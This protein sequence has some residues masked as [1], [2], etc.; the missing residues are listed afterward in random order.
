[1]PLINLDAVLNPLPELKDHILDYIPRATTSEFGIVALGS[2]INV[3]SF[4]RIYLD[5][6]EYSDRLTA[7]ETTA[8]STLETTVNTL[9]DKADELA[10]S[11]TQKLG[12]PNGIATL[13]SAGSIPSSQLP[14]YVDDVLEFL[15]VAA[16]PAIGETGKIYVETTGNTTYRWSGTTYVKLTSGEVSS[17]AGKKGIVTLTKDDVGLSNVDNT[18]DLNKPLSTATQTA[19]TALENKAKRGIINLYDTS[20]IYG[21]NE[22][23]VLTNGDIVKSTIDGNTNDP[24]VDMT[25]W[26]NVRNDGIV[27]SIAELLSVSNPKNGHVVYVKSYNAG[28]GKGGGTFVYNS[29]KAT[30][31]DGVVNFNG[32]VRASFMFVTSSMAGCVI[33]GVTDD[34]QAFQRGV[35]YTAQNNFAFYVDDGVHY[36]NTATFK[37][38]GSDHDYQ[39]YCPIIELKYSNIS[40]VGK[41][42]KSILKYGDGITYTGWDKIGYVGA[43]LFSANPTLQIDNF[44]LIGFTI[45]G[46]GYNNK[47]RGLNGG[48]TSAGSQ[49]VYITKGDNTRIVGNKFKDLSGYQALFIAYDTENTLVEGNEFVDT[50]WLD[51]TNWK[52]NYTDQSTI[53]LGGTYLCRNNKLTQSY[54]GMFA[55]TAFELHGIG[56]AVGNYVEKYASAFLSAAVVHNPRTILLANSA[57]D[58]TMFLGTDTQRE[59]NN[60]VYAS[61]N[62]FRQRTLKLDENTIYGQYRNMFYFFG[63]YNPTSCQVVIT[64]NTFDTDRLYVDSTDSYLKQY[65][66]VIAAAH[67]T[68]FTFS[69][70]VVSNHKG[71]FLRLLRQSVGSI[72]TISN[73]TFD[74]CGVDDSVDLGNSIIYFDNDGAQDFGVRP[75]EMNFANNTFKSCKYGQYF[76]GAKDVLGDILCPYS[77][78]VDNDVHDKW[79]TTIRVKSGFQVN[80]DFYNEYNYKVNSTYNATKDINGYDVGYNTVNQRGEIKFIENG[81]SKSFK[82]TNNSLLWTKHNEGLITL[83]AAYDPAS[84]LPNTQ[85]EYIFNDVFG[86]TLGM[87]ATPTFDK[88]LSGVQMWAQVTANQQV[89]V[90]FRNGTASAVDIPSGTLKVDVI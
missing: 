33:D 64:G 8:A 83:S 50:G 44:E 16:F 9:E 7:I 90:Y 47:I 24:N 5:T 70:N 57:I 67:V 87:S 53:Y 41:S 51:G 30:I 43:Q 27:E 38:W 78:V 14:S 37:R 48:G 61:G 84:I 89:V 31:N 80:Y 34:A 46:N 19:L 4:G 86:A 18:N 12:T 68:A 39:T 71:H 35:D 73:N 82:K 22:R 75:A 77:L 66:S 2:G 74:N 52:P 13:D 76:G 59:H 29:T 62:Y 60:Y 20:L 45:D 6:Q 36:L 21:L 11:I 54:D 15:N 26:L 17:V 32:W 56:T 10:A 65:N 3:D 23:V 55:G 28:L 85:I 25:G 69:N 42:E 49:A 63:A 81:V 72:Y 1:M 79:I 58:C 40:V 88:F